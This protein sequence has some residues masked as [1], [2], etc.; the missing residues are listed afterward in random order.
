MSTNHFLVSQEQFAPFRANSV[1]LEKLDITEE[2]KEAFR[3]L[4]RQQTRSAGP[5]PPPSDGHQWVMVID[6]QKLTTLPVKGALGQ[7]L[8]I[9]GVKWEWL[10]DGQKPTP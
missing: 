4:A 10:L 5:P 2:Q 7:P 9:C 8:V 3:N 1:P 6:C